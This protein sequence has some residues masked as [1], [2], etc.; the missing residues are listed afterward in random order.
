MIT[1]IFNRQNSF[2]LKTLE[3]QYL[4]KINLFYFHC[5]LNSSIVFVASI[6]NSIFI[7]MTKSF[8]LNFIHLG[9]MS[10]SI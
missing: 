9:N 1:S 5:L 4:T 2:S 7:L 10:E 3:K 8:L 6:N